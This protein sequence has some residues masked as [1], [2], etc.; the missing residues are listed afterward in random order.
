MSAGQGD[1]VMESRTPLEYMLA[2]MNDPRVEP[3][4]R[5]RIAVAAAPYLHPKA[6]EQGKKKDKDDAA[7]AV[8][9]GGGRFAPP[10]P[11]PRMN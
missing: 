1:V 10:E 4:R 6:G 5:D 9:E 8:A 7:R 11:P 3:N 2:V